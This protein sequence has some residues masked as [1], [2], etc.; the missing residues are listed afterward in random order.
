MVLINTNGIYIAK[1]ANINVQSLIAS[2][3]DIQN[4]AFLTGQYKFQKVNGV[5]V[6]QI[7]NEAN[8]TVKDGGY[9][10]FMADRVVNGGTITAYLGSVAFGSGQNIT[11]NFDQSGLVNLVVNKGLAQQLTNSQGETVDQ[12]VNKGTIKADG[13]RI[14]LTAKLLETTLKSIVNNSGIIEANSAVNKKGM[15]EL[16]ADGGI[17]NSRDDQ[18][19][20]IK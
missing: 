5:N 13:G 15:I 10:V 14:Q 18:R 2:T 4:E 20:A 7:L 3:L 19:L 6:A 16:V 12:I 17:D 1:S 8:I 11:V 9:V